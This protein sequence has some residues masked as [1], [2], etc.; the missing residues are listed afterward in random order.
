MKNSLMLLFCASDGSD[1]QIKL[2]LVYHSKKVFKKNY[3]IKSKLNVM[4]KAKG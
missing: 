2:L 1:L 3:A 4:G